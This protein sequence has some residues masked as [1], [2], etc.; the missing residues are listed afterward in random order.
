MT[1]C[2]CDIDIPRSGHEHVPGKGQTNLGSR[3]PISRIVLVA[4]PRHRSNNPRRIHLADAVV[5]P[6]G[7]K[8]IAFSVHMYTLGII[9]AGAG[10]RTPI[11]GKARF[12]IACYRR[13]RARGIHLT[14]A[15][16][17]HVYDVEIP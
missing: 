3:T 7:D 16:I 13:D 9:Q 1:P 6:V 8:E 4:V 10:G 12:P 5:V 11:P 14:D 17:V 2:V 15:V